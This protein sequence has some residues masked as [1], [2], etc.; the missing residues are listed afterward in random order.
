M[1]FYRIMFFLTGIIFLSVAAYYM[2]LWM[3]VAWDD[4]KP[5]EQ[6]KVEYNAM[7]PPVLRSGFVLEMFNISLLL[8]AA[9]LFYKCIKANFLKIISW[10]LLSLSGLLAYWNLFSLM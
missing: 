8:I 1:K 7:L 6:M 2:T 4:N 5:F 10:V 3:I 9:F